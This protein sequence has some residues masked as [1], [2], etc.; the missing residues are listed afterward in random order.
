MVKIN[1]MGLVARKPVRG[2]RGS[3]FQTVSSAIETSEKIEIP[4]VASLHMILFKKRITK[5]LKET[6]R[7]RRL[8]CASV[9][10]KPQKTG[11][12]AS[13]PKCSSLKL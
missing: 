3:E 2:F 9:I 6:G 8:V 13:R 11:F 7:M 5:A 1:K 4:S 10:H 12:L